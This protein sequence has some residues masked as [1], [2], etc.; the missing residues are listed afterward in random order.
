[1]AQDS[2]ADTEAQFSLRPSAQPLDAHI[3]APESDITA[4]LTAL[5]DKW[6]PNKEPG[7]ASWHGPTA[8]LDQVYEIAGIDPTQNPDPAQ[9]SEK[10]KELIVEATTVLVA[11]EQSGRMHDHTTTYMIRMIYDKVNAV[12]ECLISMHHLYL[13]ET[14]QPSDMKPD[15][16]GLW[17]FKPDDDTQPNPGQRARIFAMND[18]MIHGYRRYQ[19][20]I[21]KPVMNPDGLRTCA[22][23]KVC[24][25]KE[26]A[27]SL[28]GRRH[29]DPELWMAL[30]TGAGYQPVEQLA[31]YLEQCSD[32]EVPKI[33]PDRHVFS[34]RNGVYLAA[35]EKFIP[36]ARAHEVF[37]RNNYPTACKHFDLD[38][39]EEDIEVDDPI[40]IPTP[41]VETV[42][43]TQELSPDV[44]RWA[45]CL[46]G[47][48]MYD[49]GELDD[50]QIMPFIKGL[51]NTGKSILLTYM[52][53]LY[54]R[55]DVGIISNIIE[56]QF[57][58][59]NIAGKFIG[60]GDDLRKNF[61]LDQSEF[62]NAV[63]GNGVSCAQ[64]F[65]GTRIES[66]WHTPMIWSGNEVPGFHDNSGSYGRRLAVFLFKNM[67][68]QVDGQLLEHMMDEFARFICKCN[69]VYRNMVRRHGSKG[70]W[71]ILPQEFVQQRQELTSCSNAL[72]GFLASNQ[73]RRTAAGEPVDALYMSLDALRDAVLGYAIR[74]NLEKPQWGPDY[75]R[76]PITMAGLRISSEH[77][78]RRYP[79]HGDRQARGP[80]VL[81]LDLEINCEI[82]ETNGQECFAAVS[83]AAAAAQPTASR[84]RLFTEITE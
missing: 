81:G 2:Y 68:R 31:Q 30:T 37:P 56:K 44:R 66:P 47:R 14:K 4:D 72:V 39:V 23:E 80:F 50:W 61:Q 10:V 65:K 28:T 46:L 73:I 9:I 59:G 55:S 74:N 6:F 43:D 33:V 64:K 20:I 63:T 17:R 1:M 25:I 11:L 15:Q 83:E 12:K 75:Y 40:N 60:I 71:E 48:L 58:L 32:P 70:I 24:T 16:S 29:T 54:E 84:K 57:G 26:Y 82:A 67:V 41:S 77:D 21:V 35:E 7:Q 18:L 53:R 51:A 45:Y 19:D 27:S 79:R 22:W 76:G 62:Q 52:S 5:W 69:R 8:I 3:P 49:V 34:F 78:R 38:F 42:F 36:Y 13:A